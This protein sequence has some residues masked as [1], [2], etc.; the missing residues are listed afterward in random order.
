MPRKVNYNSTDT[1]DIFRQKLN[2]EADYVG[3]LDDLNEAIKSGDPHYYSHGAMDSSLDGH[4]H[5]QSPS[6]LSLINALNL[7]ESGYQYIYNSI[8][9]GTANLTVYTLNVESATFNVVRTGN[10][11]TDSDFLILDSAEFVRASGTTIQFDS[12]EIDSARINFLSGSYLKF[13]SGWGKGI[14]GSTNGRT[15]PY[16]P[17]QGDFNILRFDS[18]HAD[19][20]IYTNISGESA[21]YPTGIIA[22]LSIDSMALPDTVTDTITVTNM[23]TNTL[24]FD[25]KPFIDFTVLRVTDNTGTIQLAGYLTSRNLDSAIA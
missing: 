8:N 21:V 23:T 9:D 2:Q 12:A 5:L 11:I 24:N 17:G 1:F 20:S 15:A 3:N 13:D 16:W 19:S 25:D 22:G 7:I 18:L 10:I 6:S 14:D 4:G